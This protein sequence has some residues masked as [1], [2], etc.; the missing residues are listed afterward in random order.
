MKI[1]IMGAGAYGTALGGILAEK[2]YDIDYYDPKL[3]KEPLAQVVDKAAF[4]VLVAPSFAL[5]YLLPHLPRKVPLIVATKGILDMR[6]IG[7]FDD[8]M[9]LSGPGFADDMKAHAKTVLTATDARVIELF[10]T[11]YLSFDY[12]ADLYGV[13]LCGALK[14][15]YAVLA[16]MSEFEAGSPEWEEFISLVCG[17]MKA[18]LK[19]NGADP[20]TVNLVCGV[21]DLR[22][23]CNYPSRNYEFGRILRAQPHAEPKKT[24]EGISTLAKLRRGELV[25]PE[26]A[27][28]LRQLIE[29][30]KQWN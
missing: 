13:L 10:S 2:G 22:L 6:Q 20:M 21:G 28:Q 29:I 25:I 30:S 11:D 12:T 18:I 24:V 5:P 19:A 9:A 17:E 26:A 23:T 1:A 16:G 14:N 7:G 3:Y 4:V 27:V 8:V 15:V